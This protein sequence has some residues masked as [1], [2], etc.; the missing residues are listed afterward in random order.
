[1]FSISKSNKGGEVLRYEGL[2]YLHKKTSLNGNITWRCRY[3]KQKTC[4][5][6][7]ITNLG[8]I[9]RYPNDHSHLG[10]PIKS[11]ACAIL[12]QIKESASTSKAST[13]AIIGEHVMNTRLETLHRFPKKSS[14]ERKIQRVREKVNLPA[15]HPTTLNFEIPLDYLDMVHYDSGEEDPDRILAFGDRQ[16]IDYLNKNNCTWFGDGTFDVVPEL[17]FQLYTIHTKIGNSYPPCVYFLL[18]NKSGPTYTRMISI[19]NIIIP[20]ANPARILVDF[21]QAPINAFRLQYPNANMSGCFFHLSQS[22]IRKLSECGLKKR[23]ETDIG[24][25]MLVKSLP[26]LAFVP[27]DEVSAIFDEVASHF[28]EEE[29]CNQFLTYFQSTY[30]Q[31]PIIRRRARKPRFEMKFW[32]HY[33]DGLEC[34]QKTTNC[35]EG[36]HNALNSLFL[37]SHPT[38]WTFFSGLQKDIAIHRLTVANSDVERNVLQ[39]KKYIKIAEKLSQKVTRF[40][41]EQDKLRYLRAIANIQVSN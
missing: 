15:P 33:N 25:N 12:S 17:Y 20:N 38:M 6:T 39:K 10:S 19:L 4:K 21:E 41:T 31:G 37:C 5:S 22:V 11:E 13:R 40:S 16:I 18:T 34:E 28:P 30:I 14:V 1:M 27:I 35:V 24:F 2:D 32:N 36:Y 29:S 3:H 26:A 8:E 7:L 23:F 9:I